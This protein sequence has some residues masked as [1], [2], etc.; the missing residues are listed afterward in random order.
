MSDQGKDISFSPAREFNEGE[1]ENRDKR[2]IEIEKLTPEAKKEYADF[3]RDIYFYYLKFRDNHEDVIDEVASILRKFGLGTFDRIVD[4]VEGTTYGKDSNSVVTSFDS[5]KSD[6]MRKDF[7]AMEDL[8]YEMKSKIREVKEER[9]SSKTR[10]QALEDIFDL[11]VKL[12]SVKK[13]FFEALI[14]F[15][16]NFTIH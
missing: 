12:E 6:K 16:K 13:D 7:T 3:Y 11:L 9:E 4:E 5:D 15:R 1:I 10:M 8:L 2:I 14:D